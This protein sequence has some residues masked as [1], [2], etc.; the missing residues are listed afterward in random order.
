M[1]PAEAYPI[2]L[3]NIL[4][5]KPYFCHVS[6]S[7]LKVLS[8]AAILSL[9]PA[10]AKAHEAFTI[11]DGWQFKFQA[12]T[13]Y[14]AVHIPH[15]WNEDA[16][17]SRNYRRGT[18]IYNKSLH[19]PERFYDKQ[20]YLRIDGAASKSEI[21]IDGIPVGKH[22]GA[23]SSHTIDITPYVKAGSTHNLTISAVFS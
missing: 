23:Y 3:L 20:I 1:P 6:T 17:H 15:C 9:S 16:Y 21:K 11:N 2:C 13:A 5:L 22:T 19:I 10:L 4:L 12:D 18:A 7:L 14:T 8:L